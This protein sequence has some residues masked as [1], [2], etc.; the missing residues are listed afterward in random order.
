MRLGS[1]SIGWFHVAQKA[2]SV[3]AW[4]DEGLSG[5]WRQRATNDGSAAPR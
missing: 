2:D 1:A 3:K 4:S 5:F